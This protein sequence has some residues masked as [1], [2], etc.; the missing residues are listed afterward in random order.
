M[1]ADLLFVEHKLLSVPIVVMNQVHSILIGEVNNL[2]EVP[3]VVV[4]PEDPDAL[5]NQLGGFLPEWLR[6][7]LRYGLLDWRVGFSF[8]FR[9]RR[10]WLGAGFRSRLL[11][12]SFRLGFRSRPVGLAGR[13]LLAE[14]G[15][16]GSLPFRRGR[17]LRLH[18]KTGFSQAGR[19]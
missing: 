14:E 16:Q 12:L 17:L 18:V 13:F 2:A 19:Q 10:R 5:S 9:G 1:A 15:K 7:G 4:S 11:R 6:A 8:G 3:I